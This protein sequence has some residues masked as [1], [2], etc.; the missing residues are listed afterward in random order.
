MHDDHQFQ[1]QPIYLS[2]Q[3]SPEVQGAATTALLLEILLGILLALLGIGHAYSG[4]TRL[5]IVLMVAWWIYVAI[6]LVFSILTIGL[7][8]WLCLPLYL[9]VP[10]ISGVRARTYALSLGTKGNWRS[11]G[12]VAGGGCLILIL[13]AVGL[14]VIAI[15]TGVIFR[16]NA[17]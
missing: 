4:R 1:L 17:Q 2:R 11:V 15:A 9:V 14:F 13:F 10:V 6:S 5:G 12:L 8:A 7:G 3:P 16:T